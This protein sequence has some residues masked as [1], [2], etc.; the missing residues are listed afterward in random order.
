MKRMS[1]EIRD[2]NKG[3]S[4]V[5]EKPFSSWND[6]IKYKT[7]PVNFYDQSVVTYID[8]FRQ[9]DKGLL[10]FTG[11]LLEQPNKIM[12]IFNLIETL[13]AE[14]ERERLERQQKADKRM[15]NKWRTK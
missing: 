12:E 4:T 14:N 1:Q 9:F 7:C 13:K 5:L 10:P 15:Q 3:C 8:L 2:K 11:G 6:D